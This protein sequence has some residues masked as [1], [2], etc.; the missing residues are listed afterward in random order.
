MTESGGVNDGQ[1]NRA[2]WMHSSYNLEVELMRLIMECI[3]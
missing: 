3:C 2:K 1:G